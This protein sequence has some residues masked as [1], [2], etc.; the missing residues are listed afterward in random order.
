MNKALFCAAAIIL[1]SP[2]FSGESRHNTTR[3]G[4]GY[5]ATLRQVG[6]PLSG[7]L[8]WA[9]RIQ[10]PGFAAPIQPVAVKMAPTH[11]VAAELAKPAKDS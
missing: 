7:G 6:V 1:S 11:G 5:E 2:A 3:D 9:T 10:P 4:G 8:T